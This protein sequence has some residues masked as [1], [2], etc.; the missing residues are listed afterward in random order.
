VID[1]YASI[2]IIFLFVYLFWDGRE[3]TKVPSEFILAVLFFLLLLR[4]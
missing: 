1:A 2:C 4:G 3:K